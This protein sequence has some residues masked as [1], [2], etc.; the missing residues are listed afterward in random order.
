MNHL[1][2]KNYFQNVISFIRTH[3]T[4]IVLTFDFRIANT[5][6]PPIISF[7]T[8][9]LKTEY[10]SSNFDSHTTKITI[11]ETSTVKNLDQNQS[12]VITRDKYFQAPHP[13]F[14]TFVKVEL[15][16]LWISFI[17]E[18]YLFFFRLCVE[19]REIVAFENQK[20]VLI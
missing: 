19:K 6:P 2:L 20:I 13:I 7:R 8:A 10:F 12:R 1:V 3:H 11:C 16:V 9:R 15:C 18:K 17:L 5:N 4:C 14:H